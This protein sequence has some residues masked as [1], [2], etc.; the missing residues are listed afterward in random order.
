MV[1]EG[2]VE[3][4]VAG[5]DRLVPDDDLLDVGMQPGAQTCVRATRQPWGLPDNPRG[6]AMS[7]RPSMHEPIVRAGTRLWEGSA[8][9]VGRNW[10][11]PIRG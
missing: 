7:S 3:A 8:P 11:G 2:Q 10:R 5:E 1:R 9:V 6:R 4:A